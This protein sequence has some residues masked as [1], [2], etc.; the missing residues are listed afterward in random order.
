MRNLETKD[1]NTLRKSIIIRLKDEGDIH[2]NRIANHYEIRYDE[3]LTPY[4]HL[5]AIQC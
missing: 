5:Y 1:Y 2:V 3:K 4:V